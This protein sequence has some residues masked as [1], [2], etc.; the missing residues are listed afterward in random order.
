MLQQVLVAYVTQPVLQAQH[1]LKLR[2]TGPVATA[3]AAT[4]PMV[5]QQAADAGCCCTSPCT[6][7]QL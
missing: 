4:W 3:A 7:V 6:P 5:A 1:S 2:L